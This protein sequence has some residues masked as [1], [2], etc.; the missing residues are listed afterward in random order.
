MEYKKF[1]LVEDLMQK[2]D[3]PGLDG[4]KTDRVAVKFLLSRGVTEGASDL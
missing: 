2:Y 1:S 3:Y 4:H